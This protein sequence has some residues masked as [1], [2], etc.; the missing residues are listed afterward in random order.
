MN[1]R[2]VIP[3]QSCRL[4]G[5]FRWGATR[6]A[7]KWDSRNNNLSLAKIGRLNIR[8]SRSFSAEPS[9]V[10]ISVTPTGK[11]FVSIRIDEPNRCL[12]PAT[13]EIGID[14]GIKTLA[15]TSDGQCFE[16]VR[17]ISKHAKR[18][19]FEQRRLSRRTKGSGRWNRARLRVAK[20]QERIANIRRD[21]LHKVTTKLVSENQTLVCETLRASNMMKNRKLAKSIAD[22]S[23]FELVRQLA[24]KSEWYGRTFVQIS[25]WEP[26]SKRCSCCGFVSDKMPLSIRAWTCPECLTEHD[27][28]ENAAKNILEA[29]RALIAQGENVSRKAVSPVARKSRRT[30]K[31]L[32]HRFT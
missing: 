31:H 22:C 7:F 9:T 26:T 6:S 23:W 28:D 12:P 14:L 3:T 11:Y 25:Q 1:V 30:V 4:R 19:A 27:R 13:A 10:T 17:A 2:S 18:L 29:G 8:W 5:I 16:N 20:I 24:Y 15:V 32:E 21:W